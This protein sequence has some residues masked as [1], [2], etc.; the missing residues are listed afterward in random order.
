[1]RERERAKS[2]E[3]KQRLTLFSSS[4]SLLA[5][6]FLLLPVPL[7]VIAREA[8]AHGSRRGDDRKKRREN[9]N[10]EANEKGFAEKVDEKKR[11]SGKKPATTSF[12]LFSSSL[13]TPP[14]AGFEA[15]SI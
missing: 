2:G 7:E 15:F 11:G 12:P 13:P 4:L 8:F 10:E 9:E 1:M 14:P 5:L 6:G 3:Q